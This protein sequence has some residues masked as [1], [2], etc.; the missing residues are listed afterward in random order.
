MSNGSDQRPAAHESA[1]PAGLRALGF[2]LGETLRGLFYFLSLLPTFLAVSYLRPTHAAT[3]LLIGIAGFYLAGA[4]LVFLLVLAKRALVGT[5]ETNRVVT[6]E[7]SAGKRFYFA[8]MLH[9]VMLSS[10]FKLMISTLSPL[11]PYYYRGMGARMASSVFISGSA[12][13]SDPWFLEM[14]E[15]ATVGGGTVILG[16]A[17]D[18]RDI[19]L[20]S[21][22]VGE[23]AIIG[24]RC[25]VLPNTRIGRHAR[26]G[27]GAV[28]V[29][30][31]VIPDGETWAGVPARK[32]SSRRDIVPD[33]P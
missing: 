9:G 33:T 21:V 5:L 32:I 28:V 16:H 13:I 2:V 1:P 7:T 25:V 18:G 17:G 24:A 23:G 11:A 14:H 12:R 30:G 15:N 22:F 6:I 20:G 27:A 19:I 26:V 4:L 3:W 29:R 10:P 31:T 8:S